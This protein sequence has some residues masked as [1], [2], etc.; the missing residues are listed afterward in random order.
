MQPG[1]R[2][3]RTVDASAVEASTHVTTVTKRPFSVTVI[4][5]LFIA[6]GTVGLIY[7]AAEFRTARVSEVIP[8]CLIRL[9]ALVCGVFMLRGHNWARWALL[10]WIAYHVV[11][12]GFHSLFQ[13]AVHGL[14]LGIVAWFLFRPRVS[15]YFRAAKAESVG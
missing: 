14:L 11:L 7:H 13:F 9:L 4:A 15:A 3:E 10:V 6:A 8:I 1:L 2:G 5:W 12:S